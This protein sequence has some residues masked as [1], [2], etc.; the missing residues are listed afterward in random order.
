MIPGM[1]EKQSSLTETVTDGLAGCTTDNKALVEENARL[2]ASVVALEK[3]QAGL[4]SDL[5]DTA[6]VA[7][8]IPLDTADDLKCSVKTKG[9]WRMSS[10][11]A[12][13]VCD[14]RLWREITGPSPGVTCLYHNEGSGIVW[15]VKTT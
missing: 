14:G 6:A 13:E 8:R 10:G 5:K 1:V 7:A 11:G 4:V 3:K 2:S 12:L 9:V 15:S